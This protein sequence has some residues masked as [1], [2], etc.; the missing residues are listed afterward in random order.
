MV[1]PGMPYLDIV[2]RLN[3]HF[4]VPIAVYQVSGEYAMLKMAAQAGVLDERTAVLE[5]MMAFRRAG[6]CGILTYFAKQVAQWLQ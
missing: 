5:S 4:P 6:A 3:D 2:R 1:K